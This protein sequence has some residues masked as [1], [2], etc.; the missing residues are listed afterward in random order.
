MVRAQNVCLH[1]HAVVRA[2]AGDVAR[3]GKEALIDVASLVSPAVLLVVAHARLLG[4]PLIT[5]DRRITAA[6][7]D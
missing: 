7:D 3:P 2:Y 1:T 6:Y 4:V 5:R